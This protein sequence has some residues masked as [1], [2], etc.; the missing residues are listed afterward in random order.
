LTPA[1]LREVLEML[2]VAEPYREALQRMLAFA[3]HRAGDCAQQFFC[4]LLEARAAGASDPGAV[5]LAA[6]RRWL[7]R[8]RLDDAALRPIMLLDQ[9]G[10]ERLHPEVARRLP[11]RDGAESA[12]PAPEVLREAIRALPRPERRALDACYLRPRRGRK[13]RQLLALAE[14]GI[15]QLREVLLREHVAA[16]MS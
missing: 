11:Q 4:V 5:A 14:R 7:R 2:D 15:E 12:S 9:A 6:T 13:S 16:K 3:S 8:Q 1:G 10:R